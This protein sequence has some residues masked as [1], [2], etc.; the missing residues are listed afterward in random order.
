MT[1]RKMK[2]KCAP[3]AHPLVRQ[4]VRLMQQEE[5]G[6]VELSE[7]AA[8]NPQT[9]K[10]WRVRTVPRVDMLEACF[11]A[12]GYRLAVVA[13]DGFEIGPSGIAERLALVS[14]EA[15]RF[16]DFIAAKTDPDN[17]FG[18]SPSEKRLWCVLNVGRPVSTEF[19]TQASGLSAASLSVYMCRIRKAVKPYGIVVE[20]HWGFGFEV[21]RN[22][23]ALEVAA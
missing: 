12:L 19:L 14:A 15:E 6:V 3:K 17:A 8:V 23:P 9:L 13:T 18:F 16:R 5:C 7:R 22:A 21:K 10:D 1:Y 2:V 11:N 20:T 4:L